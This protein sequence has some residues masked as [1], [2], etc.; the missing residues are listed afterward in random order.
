MKCNFFQGFVA[1]ES[2]S[3][4]GHYIHHQS[5]RLKIHNEDES[6]LFKNDASFE[7]VT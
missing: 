3:Q 4:P 7:L 5:Y 6:E 1:F 2:T